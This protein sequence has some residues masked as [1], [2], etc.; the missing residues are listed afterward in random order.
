MDKCINLTDALDAIRVKGKTG[1]LQV[2]FGSEVREILKGIPTADAVSVVRC[3]DCQFFRKYNNDDDGHCE[4][5]FKGV[6][7]N[8]YCSYG[9]VNDEESN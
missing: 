1:G 7:A 4:I 5:W 8:D 2:Y 3:S 6:M 9:E